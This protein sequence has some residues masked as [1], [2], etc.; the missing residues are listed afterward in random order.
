M[1]DSK[2]NQERKHTMKQE[3]REARKTEVLEVLKEADDVLTNI[4]EKAKMDGDI[5]LSKKVTLQIMGIELAICWI[6]DDYIEK[7]ET[8]YEHLCC[9]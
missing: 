4:R 7:G 5:L 8:D 2:R 3:A 6:E 1:M 9:N